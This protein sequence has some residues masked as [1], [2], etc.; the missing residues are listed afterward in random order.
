MRKGGGC[1]GCV[2][3]PT[4]SG[5]SVRESKE[6]IKKKRKGKKAWAK[7][8]SAVTRRD[9]DRGPVLDDD[10]NGVRRAVVDVRA[11]LVVEKDNLVK[12][13]R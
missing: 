9:L 7:E 12:W 4:T 2:L 5:V 3:Q 11:Y 6:R 1:V 10:D 13:N 8:L